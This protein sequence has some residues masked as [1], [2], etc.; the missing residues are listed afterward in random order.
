MIKVNKDKYSLEISWIENGL[1][2]GVHCDFL[3]KVGYDEVVYPV[4][5][6]ALVRDYDPKNAMFDEEKEMPTEEEAK[7]WLDMYIEEFNEKTHV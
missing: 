7:Q 1:S 4:T 3:V 5:P 6:Y 2:S